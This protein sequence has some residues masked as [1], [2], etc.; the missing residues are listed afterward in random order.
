MI[1]ELTFICPQQVQNMLFRVF[2]CIDRTILY[3]RIHF[4]LIEMI[5]LYISLHFFFSPLFRYLSNSVK[6]Q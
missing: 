5:F 2:T 1:R 4:L 3:I 6:K